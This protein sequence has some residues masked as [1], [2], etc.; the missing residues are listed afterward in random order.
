MAGPA[1]SP[2]V[3]NLPA[4]DCV[5]VFRTERSGVY[6]R[7]VRLGAVAQNILKPHALPAVAATPLG[8]AVA[9]AAL[10]GSALPE[11][12]NIAVQTK[13]NGIVSMLYADCEAPGQLR[14]YARCDAGTLAALTASGEPLNAENLIGAGHLA[15]TIDMQ[16]DAAPYQGV[17]ALDGATLAQSA[18]HY[19][20]QR[21]ALPTFV[22]LA[23]AQHYAGA[24]NGLP[25]Q[26]Q[27][28][29]GGIMIQDPQPSRDDESSD[30]ADG[31]DTWQRVRML[32]AT[33]EDHELLDPALTAERLLL[34]LF[35]E[36]GVVIERVVP[37]RSY[38]KCSR[39]KIAKVLTTF[40][41]DDIRDMRDDA[42]NITVTCEFCATKYAFDAAEIAALQAP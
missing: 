8:E 39:D 23:V 9:L 28:R 41:A 10:L 40:G 26:M 29:C 17:I 32:T 18:A 37:L 20:E 27:W 1:P 22:R 5:I 35:H 30:A 2:A 33:I 25:V 3:L 38:C 13:T 31:D 19:F 36:E 24:H 14:G 42:G 11:R 7:L 4:D 12:G 21:E 34:R 16:G 6:G 15:F